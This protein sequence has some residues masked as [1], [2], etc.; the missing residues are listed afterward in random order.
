M[1]CKFKNLAVLRN[2]WKYD[3][4]RAKANRNYIS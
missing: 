1:F 4:N 2:I 3:I